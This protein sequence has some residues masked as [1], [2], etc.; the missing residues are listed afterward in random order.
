M[1][2]SSFLSFVHEYEKQRQQ[3]REKEKEDENAMNEEREQ[4][5]LPTPAATASRN[6]TKRRAF[7]ASLIGTG[8]LDA[9]TTS[10]NSNRKPRREKDTSSS[11]S[12][13]VDTIS[14]PI[15]SNVG[16]TIGRTSA[17]VQNGWIARLTSLTTKKKREAL[18]EHNTRFIRKREYVVMDNDFESQE[19]KGD[20]R[21]KAMMKLLEND[22]K[23]K[24]SPDQ[25]LYCQYFI[26]ACLPKIY[27]EEWPEHCVR[28]LE[29]FGI[30]K[31]DYEVMVI[32]AR[33]CGK[34][35]AV[36]MFALS[37]LLCV[38]GI[39]IAIFSTGG[40]AS[41]SLYDI[42]MTMLN[43]LPHSEGYDR[44]VKETKEH[45]FIAHQPIPKGSSK[46]SSHRKR[47]RT[48]K[49]TSRLYAFPDTVD[50]NEI[51]TY[52]IYIIQIYV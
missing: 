31:I 35:F 34:S 28:V 45:L 29:E 22:L 3:L 24:R 5:V 26:L 41:G 17:L 50:S 42:I 2:A 14:A 13:S 4:G 12:S 30:T 46:N 8:L 9:T 19:C 32:T 36:A 15:P 7:D 20:K 43:G 6:A 40:R 37:L 39:Q 51:H 21:L 25:I 11:S 23:I 33:R 18:M 27:G 44:V 52:I 47:L 49:T 16:A 38:P 10:T 48:D 1:S